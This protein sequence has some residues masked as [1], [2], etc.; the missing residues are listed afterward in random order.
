MQ[1]QVKH[2]HEQDE[3][4]EFGPQ[5]RCPLCK[6]VMLSGTHVYLMSEFNLCSEIMPEHGELNIQRLRVCENTLTNK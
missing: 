1:H 3:N 2:E 5:K 4:Y 6:L